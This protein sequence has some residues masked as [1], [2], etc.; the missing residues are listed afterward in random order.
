MY[1]LCDCTHTSGSADVVTLP[2]DKALEAF[3]SA[4]A[5]NAQKKCVKLIETSFVGGVLP[6]STYKS[7]SANKAGDVIRQNWSVLAGRGSE[8]SIAV[9]GKA[10]KQSKKYK[11]YD[12]QKKS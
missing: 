4:G 11:F 2:I 9:A 8:P 3:H 6:N 5:S 1:L 10:Q 7:P 12:Q